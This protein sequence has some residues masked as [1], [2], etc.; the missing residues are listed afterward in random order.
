[1]EKSYTV[2]LEY[3]GKTLKDFL[4]RG[5][6]MSASLIRSVKFLS[7]G[8]TVDGAAAFTT[9]SL[10]AGQTVCV[11]FPLDMNGVAPE[12]GEL[13]VLFECED[14]LVID[15]PPAIAVHPTLNYQGGTVA[16]LFAGMMEERGEK[17]LFRPVYRLDKD[18]SG[19]LLV[20][21]SRRSAA[22]ARLC[23]KTYL[24]LVEGEPRRSGTID[25]PIG[26]SEGSIIKRAVTVDGK[27]SKTDYTTIAYGDGCAL[28][29]FKLYTGR[30]HQIRVHTSHSGFPVMGDT[31]YG[32]ASSRIS[33]QA[34]HC[35]SVSFETDSSWRTVISPI[36]NDIILAAQAS[37]IDVALYL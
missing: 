2:P 14:F 25:L 3:D 12:Y 36:P 20:A 4:R 15:K 19:C 11:R 32:A 21:K 30:T 8:L 22:A 31:L 17:L 35:Y 6:G 9:Y 13:S 34:L 37:G 7:G 24:A 26:L 16:N 5:C 33:R 10:K 27:P 1:M 29:A 28:L 23:E 18:T